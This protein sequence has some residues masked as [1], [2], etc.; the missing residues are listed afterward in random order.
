MASVLT[1]I[2][3]PRAA[4]GKGDAMAELLVEQMPIVRETEPGNRV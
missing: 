4:K 3:Q 1:V 2:A